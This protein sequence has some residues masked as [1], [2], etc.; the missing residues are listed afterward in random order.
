MKGIE[1]ASGHVNRGIETQLREEAS[2]LIEKRSRDM[3]GK[4]RGPIRIKRL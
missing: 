2:R 4:S 3:S 1:K